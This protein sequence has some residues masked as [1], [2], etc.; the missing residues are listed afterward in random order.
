MPGL[1]WK[2]IGMW[3]T[4]CVASYGSFFRVLQLQSTLC[5]RWQQRQRD[6]TC[7]GANNSTWRVIVTCL[8][9]IVWIST[10][11]AFLHLFSSPRSFFWPPSKMSP[12]WS[13]RQHNANWTQSPF[14]VTQFDAQAF[15]FQIP[16][17][18]SI[19]DWWTT[20]NRAAWEVTILVSTSNLEL[21]NLHIRQCSGALV[22]RHLFP[23]TNALLTDG[24][25]AE[26]SPDCIMLN[27]IDA[28]LKS[29]ATTHRSVFQSLFFSRHH[30][31]LRRLECVVQ[32]SLVNCR[33]PCWNIVKNHV[34]DTCKVLVWSGLK[35]SCIIFV[36]S[37]V[38]SF[39]IFRLHMSA[40]PFLS[41]WMSELHFSCAWQDISSSC[42]H[43]RRI[44]FSITRPSQSSTYNIQMDVSFSPSPLFWSIKM[45]F[46]QT[47][48]IRSGHKTGSLSVLLVDINI[49]TP[50]R[51]KFTEWNSDWNSWRSLWDLFVE[52]KKQSH[53][54]EKFFQGI[55]RLFGETTGFWSDF[56]KTCLRVLRLFLWA[57]VYPKPNI[58]TYERFSNDTSLSQTHINIHADK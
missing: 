39:V 52:Q 41:Y 12:P 47:R 50:R 16:M 14:F 4:F 57:F 55:T 51:S 36:V 38:N 2:N 17:T 21:I 31:I 18:F 19:A 10:P 45:P 13:R 43:S 27:W 48:R 32:P 30:K 56:K 11:C 22:S 24:M 20:V 7:V 29:I 54:W 8:I 42:W 49:S 53:T 37:F 28:F 34:W 15:S 6:V 26:R 33:A 3:Q 35:I 46:G 9:L 40:I 44:W 1:P 23:L 25:I 58:H 5:W